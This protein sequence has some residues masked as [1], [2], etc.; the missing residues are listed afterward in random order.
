MCNGKSWSRWIMEFL[1]HW[2]EKKTPEHPMGTASEWVSEWVEHWL[3]SE[4]AQVYKCRVRKNTTKNGSNE[5]FSLRCVFSFEFATLA[6]PY[7]YLFIFPSYSHS[8]SVSL[9]VC[10]FYCVNFYFH[11]VKCCIIILVYCSTMLKVYCIVVPYTIPHTHTH[12][13][14]VFAYSQ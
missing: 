4:N 11:S 1:Q 10:F 14:K 7:V 13:S 3:D 6:V 12:K 5:F 2:K 8:L 9:C